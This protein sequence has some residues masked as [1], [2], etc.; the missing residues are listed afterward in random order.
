[1]TTSIAHPGGPVR[2]EV[3]ARGTSATPRIRAWPS[4]GGCPARVRR[5]LPRGTRR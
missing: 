3:L 4:G 5:V 2:G 1:L